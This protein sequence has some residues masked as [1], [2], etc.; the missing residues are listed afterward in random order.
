ME[1]YKLRNEDVW[2]PLNR[3]ADNVEDDMPP[4][5]SPRLFRTRVVFVISDAGIVCIPVDGALQGK[6]KAWGPE[7]TSTLATVNNLSNLYKGQGKLD[8]A[9]KMYQCALQ[10]YENVLGRERMKTYIPALNTMQNLAVLYKQLG[11]AN[12]TKD[13]YSRA[14]DGLEVVLGRSS[15]R[16]QDILTALAALRGADDNIASSR[17]CAL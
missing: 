15:K 12:K 9:D 3:V 13:M 7:H 5:D 16:C 10:G 11:L 2:P 14:L 1:E 8:E 17:E 6:E 4:E